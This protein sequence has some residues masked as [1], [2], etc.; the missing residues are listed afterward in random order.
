M[1]WLTTWSAPEL[2]LRFQS[3]LRS[4]YNLW[5]HP[6]RY[7]SQNLSCN[8]LYSLLVE[9]TKRCPVSPDILFPTVVKH[10]ASALKMCVDINFIFHKTPEEAQPLLPLLLP[11]LPQLKQLVMSLSPATGLKYFSRFRPKLA[12]LFCHY[13]VNAHQNQSSQC[14]C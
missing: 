9:N 1:Y 4:L 8:L 12:F 7:C 13:N 2:E 14:V 11:A 5:L 6:P 3:R 10:L